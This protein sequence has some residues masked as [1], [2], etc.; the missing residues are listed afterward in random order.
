MADLELEILA[1]ITAEMGNE[2]FNTAV[3]TAK[4]KSAYREVKRARNYPDTYSDEKI[5]K[6]MES[7]FS[8]IKNIALYD[9]NM[10]GAEGEATHSENGVSRTYIDRKSL[11]AGV[12]P[13]SR[14]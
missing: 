4:I 13:I 3:M 7:Y 10:I 8:N 2:D 11:F 14:V 12:L 1:D 5:E 9:Y 6:D